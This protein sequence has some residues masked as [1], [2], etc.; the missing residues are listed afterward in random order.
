MTLFDII[1]RMIAAGEDLNSLAKGHIQFD[2]KTKVKL[3]NVYKKSLKS[4]REFTFKF[5]VHSEHLLYENDDLTELT[6]DGITEDYSV[7][8]KFINKNK[9]R[10]SEGDEVDM[11]YPDTTHSDCYVFCNCP[12]FYYYY[13]HAD[14]NILI[15]SS[16]VSSLGVKTWKQLDP[17]KGAPQQ[18]EYSPK[19]RKNPNNNIGI[20][21]HIVA[22]VYYLLE[23]FDDSEN[24]SFKVG[25]D[26]GST[27]L[28]DDGNLINILDK[29]NI[30]V[31]LYAGTPEQK[32]EYNN[33]HTLKMIKSEYEKAVKDLA[34]SKKTRKHVYTRIDSARKAIENLEPEVKWRK[35]ELNQLSASVKKKRKELRNY[36]T[37]SDDGEV[38]YL[39]TK[40]MPKR[41]IKK[42]EKELNND[43]A[44]LRSKKKTADDKEYQLYT[45]QRTLDAL[46]SYVSS[47]TGTLER[48]INNFRKRAERLRAQ[49]KK[50]ALHWYD[51]EKNIAVD[52]RQEPNGD[53]NV[54]AKDID[55]FIDNLKKDN[56]WYDHVLDTSSDKKEITNAK[57]NKE[58]NEK[59]I[60]KWT[61]I[62][63]ERAEQKILVADINRK[64]R[65]GGKKRNE[66]RKRIKGL[67]NRVQ[68]VMTNISNEKSIIDSKI[69]EVIKAMQ[70]KDS[71]PVEKIDLKKLNDILDTRIKKIKED[72]DTL[73][74]DI[75]D[76]DVFKDE[77]TK[78]EKIERVNRAVEDK[79]KDYAVK[80]SI[81]KTY[82]RTLNLIIDKDKES[83]KEPVVQEILRRFIKNDSKNG[84]KANLHNNKKDKAKTKK[85][86]NK[87]SLERK[88]ISN[89]IFSRLQS[90]TKKVSEAL[91]VTKNSNLLDWA[92]RDKPLYKVVPT[93]TSKTIENKKSNK[94]LSLTNAIKNNEKLLTQFCVSVQKQTG[95]HL[96]E[97]KDFVHKNIGKYL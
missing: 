17:L 73:I 5:N 68:S 10:T 4:K 2:W 61:K 22:C 71:S 88:A 78:E 76:S 82:A 56:K 79:I 42:L 1:K 26:E 32:K 23:T 95:K 46:R 80:S 85:P 18:R 93:L 94:R 65:E 27:L 7:L 72:R 63:Q 84:L 8:L 35:N 57:N 49:S 60:D 16:E 54:K 29:Y 39:P 89:E 28:L 21:K 50:N 58:R 97:I 96:N 38:K 15:P 53:T 36:I 74:K 66:I 92:G 30:K 45:R 6:T 14:K 41:E 47:E 11:E 24:E 3:I 86:E 77:K 83:L 52:R 25:T 48:K 19:A 44:K 13:E 43:E 69:S 64:H 40:D 90:A 55:K 37:V 70:G 59:L 81:V 31:P 91:G 33:I 9:T 75:K 62:R 87:N 34:R 67:D 51:N 20:C 12:H